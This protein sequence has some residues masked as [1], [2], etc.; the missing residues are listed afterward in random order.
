[1]RQT[2][3]VANQK[4]G[5]GKST[6]AAHL[7]AHFAGIGKDT[8]L[9][10][11]DPQG[12]SSQFCKLRGKKDLAP[13]RC[14]TVHK[15]TLHKDIPTAKFDVCIIDAAGRPDNI[16][17]DALKVANVVLIPMCPSVSDFA[18]AADTFKEVQ[19]LIKAN[20]KVRAY[21]LYNRS[22]KLTQEVSEAQ[23]KAEAAYGIK[24]MSQSL[25]DRKSYGRSLVEGLVVSEMD[26]PKAKDE[27]SAFAK[28]VSGFLST[29][30]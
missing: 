1:M 28:E 21:A 23:T 5:V 14:N 27:F 4:G 3:V 6:I 15:A 2:I 22:G 13:F 24:F 9:V 11:T 29:V 16:Q 19:A 18:A 20:P 17:S 30:S 10:D 8:L 26:D 25:N 7:A 12:S